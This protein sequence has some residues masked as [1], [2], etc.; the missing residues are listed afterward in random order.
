KKGA[1]HLGTPGTWPRDVDTAM[2]AVD[3]LITRVLLAEKPTEREQVALF[4]PHA[5]YLV[6]QQAGMTGRGEAARLVRLLGWAQ[7]PYIKRVNLA[8]CLIAERLSEVHPALVQNPHVAT[9]EIPLPDLDLRRTYITSQL[10]PDV[11]PGEGLTM[12]GL[13]K[14]SGGLNLVNLSVA[15]SRSE[16]GTRRLDL[17]RFRELKKSRIGRN[18]RAAV[19]SA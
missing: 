10:P 16:D 2:A 14:L 17:P 7:N 18:V 9:I 11:P 6:P 15:L 1:Q 3:R 19:R 4:F 5:Q 13:A 12:E 8:M